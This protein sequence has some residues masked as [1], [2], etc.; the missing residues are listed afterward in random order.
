[1]SAAY[2]QSRSVRTGGVSSTT[3]AFTSSVTANDLL[4]YG[5]CSYN[6]VNAATDNNSN[7][8]ANA[9]PSTGGTV[10]GFARFDYV[11]ASN[12]GPTTVTGNVTGSQS[13]LLLHIWEISGCVTSSPVRDTGTVAN[14]TT[15]SVSTSGAT[16]AIGDAVIALFGG[17]GTGSNGNALTADGTAL[18]SEVTTGPAGSDECLTEF[19]S[20][21]ASGTQTFT[22]TGSAGDNLVQLIATFIGT[23]VTP[24]FLINVWN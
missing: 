15:A 24:T 14:S 12:S 4:V 13:A 21:T 2:V 18:K 3:L 22:C 10:G 23:A 8:I 19:R 16:T 11:A 17:A 6:T 1:M 7:I 9:I 5:T 20:A